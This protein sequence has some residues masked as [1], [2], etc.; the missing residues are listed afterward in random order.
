MTVVE[1][2]SAA[3]PRALAVGC[4]RRHV[5]RPDRW[6]RLLAHIPEGLPHRRARSDCGCTPVSAR[7]VECLRS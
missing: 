1:T 2:M 7:M 6:W 5:P 4:F 3:E